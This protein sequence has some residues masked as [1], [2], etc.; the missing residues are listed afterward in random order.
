MAMSEP[1]ATVG[2]VVLNW[3]RPADT[4][5]CLRALAVITVPRL[6]VTVVDNGCADLSAEA[7]AAV[8]PGTQYL[9][10]DTNLGF[11]GGANAGMRHAL[12]DGA[13]Y[14]WF[15]NNDAVPEAL[16]LAVLT[17]TAAAAP[18]VGIF[19]PKI[20]QADRP[21]RIDSVA[22]D[23]N[24]RTGRVYMTGHDELDRGQ[25]DGLSAVTAVTGCAMLVRRAVCER[26]GGFDESFFA[27][28]EDADLCLRARAAGY[29]VAAVPTARVLHHRA[30]ATADRQS[31]SS[32]Y[33]ATR[34]HLRLM[35]RHG[36]GQGTRRH[37]RTLTVVA[38]NLLYALRGASHV[39]RERVR[40]VWR[41]VTDYRRGVTG[42]AAI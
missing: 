40:A 23:V 34:N 19:G 2:A 27:Y 10:T 15:V 25:Y 18:Q 3:H 7:V 5:S 35:D 1:A 17:A 32:L 24:V 31:T 16:S 8:A 11:A 39:R 28:L 33:Y 38:L 13:E 36:Q 20:L 42:A 41:G 22:L 37:L 6:T 14:V 21:Q 12:A 29:G 30:P 9:R 4:I 26:L